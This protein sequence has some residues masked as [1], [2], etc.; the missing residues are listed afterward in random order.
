RIAAQ[1]KR[2]RSHPRTGDDFADLRARGFNLSLVLRDGNYIGR[3]ARIKYRVH[4]QRAVRIDAD[5]RSLVGLESILFDRDGVAPDVE[6]RK[7]IKA[8][9]IGCE[10]R[11]N[12]S[13]DVSCTH[14]GV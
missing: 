4:G 8:A 7:G 6:L 1:T 13:I 10:R 3:F 12:A 11:T 2:N 9:S 5:A 14:G